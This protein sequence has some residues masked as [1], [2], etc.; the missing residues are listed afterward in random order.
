MLKI[1]IL[2]LGCA[3]FL[4]CGGSKKVSEQLVLFFDPP[5]VNLDKEKAPDG[6]YPFKVQVRDLE[7][8]RL[9]DNSNVVMRSG[10]YTVKF[11]K[12]GL[13]AVRPNITASGLLQETLKQN[14]KFRA[15]KERFSESSPDYIITGTVD[16]IE[17]DIRKE[18]GRSA[19]LNLTLQ[20]IRNTDDQIV[21]E[22]K[23]A[24]L[25]PVTDLEGYGSLA[26]EFSVSLA[27]IYR[28]FIVD[29]VRVFNQELVA[30]NAKND[31][32]DQ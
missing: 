6:G 28:L 17:E 5:S 4:S 11:S 29:A 31:G 9:Y 18:E 10:D 1:L 26:K 30:Y 3:G 8:N 12:R 2:C 13:W 21:F 19:A 24:R 16:N 27:E 22:R 15:L 25:S 14:L 20:I 7:L 23:Y 32:K